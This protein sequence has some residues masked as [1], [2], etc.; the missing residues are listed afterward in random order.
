[1]NSSFRQKVLRNIVDFSKFWNKIPTVALGEKQRDIVN[2][3]LARELVPLKKVSTSKG[4]ILFSCPGEIPL[5]HVKTLFTREPDTISW[6]DSITEGETLWDIGANIG[7][8]SLYAARRGVNVLAFEPAS[9]N[10]INLTQNIELNRFDTLISAY[11]IAFSEHTELNSLNMSSTETGSA[12]HLFG[13]RID[14][15][16]VRG[17]SKKIAFQQAMLSYSVDDFVEA[18]EPPLPH[19]IKLDVDGL[20]YPIIKGAKKTL[21]TPQLKSVLIELDKNQESYKD[22]LEIFSWAGLQL[23]EVNNER[24]IKESGSE[25]ETKESEHIFVRHPS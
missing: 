24:V 21:A 12:L 3:Y 9:V 2:T 10:Y 20:E 23:S 19:H 18:F 5:H 11:C 1:M 4:N 15:M 14:E 6:L 7:T 25:F 13:D 16:V 8:F 17:R 22:I